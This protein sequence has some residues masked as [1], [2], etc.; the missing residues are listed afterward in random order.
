MSDAETVLSP[1]ALNPRAGA[2]DLPAQAGRHDRPAMTAFVEDAATETALREGLADSGVPLD[3]RRGGIRGAIAALRKSATPRVLIVDVSGVTEPLSAL[4]DLSFVTE[5]D[6]RVLVIGEVNNL[7]FYREV[8]RGLGAQ[9]YLTK[10][11]TR[12]M[13]GRHF[14]PLLAGRAPVADQGQGGRVISITGVRGGV[15]ATT[16]AVNLAHHFGIAAD[17]HTVL[18]D[19]D[20]HLGTAAMLLDCPSGPGLRQALENPERVDELFVERSAQPVSGRLHVLSGEVK[21]A[22]QPVYARNAGATLLAA[23]GRRYNFVICDVPF[24]PLPL[25]RELLDQAHQRILVMEPTLACVRDALR[26]LA[27]PA[28]TSQGK[29]PVIVLNRLGVTGSLTRRK[30]EEALKCKVDVVIADLPRAV[31]NAATLGE[32]I[33]SGRNAFRRGIV[34]LARLTATV[35]QLDGA[36]TVHEGEPAQAK[37]TWWPLGKK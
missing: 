5:P 18:L 17:R 32:A 36:T 37:K 16:I 4:N 26:L 2:A 7:D 8:T 15:G 28:G 10:P 14:A 29:R 20:L 1:H 13:I 35:R 24:A 21:L 25:Y 31:E 34:E 33:A 9:E 19:P 11:I 22:E 23:L 30:V 6:V 12:D 3:I 27:L